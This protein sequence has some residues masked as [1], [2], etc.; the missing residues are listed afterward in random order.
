MALLDG[1]VAAGH[2]VAMEDLLN[3]QD[4]GHLLVAGDWESVA[5]QDVLHADQHCDVDQVWRN[6]QGQ[7]NHGTVTWGTVFLAASAA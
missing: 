3:Q 7:V 5:I 1:S 4:T 6:G 2:S